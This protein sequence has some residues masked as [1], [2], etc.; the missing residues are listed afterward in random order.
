MDEMEG[1]IESYDLGNQGLTEQIQELEQDDYLT[2]EL[3]ALKS[4][5]SKIGNSQNITPREN[6]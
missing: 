2:A 4:R 6:G 3:D 1:E 5:M